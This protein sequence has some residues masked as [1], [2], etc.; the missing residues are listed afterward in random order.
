MKNTPLIGRIEERKILEQA[1]QS[2]KAEMVSVIGRR[3]V[4]KTFLVRSVYEGRIDFEI[5][6]IQHATRKEQLR[7]FM[8]QLANFSKGSFPQTEPKDWL[9]AFHFLTKFLEMKQKKEKI[10]VFLD[11]LPWLS[12]HRSGFLKGLSFFWNSWAVNQNIVVV[13]CGSAASWM[14]RKVVHH[15]GGLH[16]RITR[17]LTLKPFNLVETEDFLKAK[18]I[19][20]DHYQILHLY[21]AMG[22]VPHYLDEIEAGK[23]AAQNINQICFS[24]NGLLHDEFSK[25]Y[26]ALFESSEAHVKVIRALAKKRKG[27]TRSEIVEESRLPEGGG[28]TKVLEELLHSG[29]ISMNYP[30]GKKKKHSLYRLTDEYS[31]FYIRFIENNRSEGK[32]VW[33]ELSQTQTYTSWAGYAFESI[34]LKHLPQ[35]K[36]ALGISGVYSTASSFYKKGNEEE[37]GLQIDLL[38][39]RKDH[40]INICEMKFYSAEVTITKAMAT[41]LRQKISNF[42]ESAKTRKQIFLT[43]ITT[44][45]LKQNKHTLGLV[46]IALT[47]EDLF[48]REN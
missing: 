33:Q 40:V 27:L 15:K 38:I 46:D 10:V 21:M 16:N 24:E 19:N 28:T 17:R 22:G 45:G 9:E 13:I 3:R 48:G 25:L 6:G 14:I 37:E 8:I 1:L 47:M 4:G 44:F 42:K 5:T 29:F 31:L 23:S 32:G 20:L 41:E 7:N 2:P 35:I 36:K 34:C 39:D 12:T 11:E 26:S 43:L 18:N 30:F